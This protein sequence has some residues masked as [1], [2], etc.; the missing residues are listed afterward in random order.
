MRTNI[1]VPSPGLSG[2]LPGIGPSRPEVS[3]ARTLLTIELTVVQ[4]WHSRL[5]CSCHRDH[6]VVVALRRPECPL[7][8][9]STVLPSLP[10]PQP[11]KGCVLAGLASF[12]LAG[13]DSSRAFLVC[14]VFRLVR[15][16][17]S[18]GPLVCLASLPL[19]LEHPELLMGLLNL[20][21]PSSGLSL[22]LHRSTRVDLSAE[23][24]RHARAWCRP[25][26][27]AC[28]CVG[29]YALSV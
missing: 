29:S 20:S 28:G 17:A 19:R 11:L 7:E 23:E 25:I 22:S 10:G 16:L 18:F 13:L 6:S 12:C 4:P 14:Q 26:V 5:T 15:S 27:R 24:G 21:S 8:P 9:R 1:A 3:S 2:G